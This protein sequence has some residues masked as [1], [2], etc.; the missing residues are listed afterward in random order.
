MNTTLHNDVY[1]SCK[2]VIVMPCFLSDTI[3]KLWSNTEK[4][5]SCYKM[6]S[7]DAD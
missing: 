6:Q 2:A 4:G 3:S 7:C 5:Y 1:C